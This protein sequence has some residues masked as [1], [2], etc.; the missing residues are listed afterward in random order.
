MVVQLHRRRMETKVYNTIKDIIT[1]KEEARKWPLNTNI[2][3][4][5]EAL[6]DVPMTEIKNALNELYK[7]GKIATANG[8]NYLLIYLNK[9]Q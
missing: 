6:P 2:L 9:E 7:K 8:I 3:A 4:I 1:R 5:A